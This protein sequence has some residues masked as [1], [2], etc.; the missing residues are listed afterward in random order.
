MPFTLRSCYLHSFLENALVL[1]S[2]D[3]DPYPK[4]FITKRLD[5]QSRIITDIEIH[6]EHLSK[7]S[8]YAQA[9]NSDKL[10]VDFQYL[11]FSSL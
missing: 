1:S 3:N 8:Q 6:K 4:C 2:W 5:F 11:D 10:G 9:Y 7:K